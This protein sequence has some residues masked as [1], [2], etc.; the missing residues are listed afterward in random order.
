MSFARRVARIKYLLVT[1][2]TIRPHFREVLAAL[3]N[4][5]AIFSNHPRLFRPSK[6]AIA[7]L[8][9]PGPNI[10]G[11]IFELASGHG[12]GAGAGLGAAGKKL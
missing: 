1:S 4:R 7:L 10:G 5:Q 9:G 3:G 12:S 2:Q 11:L 6:H 8:N